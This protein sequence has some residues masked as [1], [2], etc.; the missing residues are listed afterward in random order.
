MQV[1]DDFLVRQYRGRARLV[2]YHGDEFVLRVLI[3]FWDF[4]DAFIRNVSSLFD[5]K[6]KKKN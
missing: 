4:V 5:K 1:D 3:T 6:K 2:A